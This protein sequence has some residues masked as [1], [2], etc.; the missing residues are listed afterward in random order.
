MA[1]VEQ[2]KFDL[3]FTNT[4]KITKAKPLT[5]DDQ[6][7]IAC[8]IQVN[9]AR[10]LI[11]EHKEKFDELS[12]EYFK[13]KK[14]PLDLKSIGRNGT[15]GYKTYYELN[16]NQTNFLIT[17]FKNT[18]EVVEL[19]F[20]LVKEFKAMKDI[21]LAQ[22]MERR[23]GKEQRRLFTDAIQERH[24]NEGVKYAE[25]TNLCYKKLFGK[26]ANEIKEQV[27]ITE[28]NKCKTEKERR[29][30]Q[31]DITKIVRDYFTE[32]QLTD[33]K[34]IESECATLIR[35]GMDIKTISETLDKIYGKN[36][37]YIS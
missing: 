34:R 4:N 20:R 29:K 12:E 28:L 2:L 37:R 16:E 18:P 27:L 8:G 5:R 31:K 23:M 13:G 22:E 21:L 33:I 9:S 15:K 32:K 1:L 24:G 30:V 35:L 11:N 17:L 25:Y 10:K 14:Q 3:V 26:T 6:I 7:A 36:T 19:K